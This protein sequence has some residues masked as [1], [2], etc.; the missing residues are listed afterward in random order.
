MSAINKSDLFAD[1]VSRIQQH[2]AQTRRDFQPLTAAQLAWSPQPKEWSILQCID[3]LNQTH[4]YYRARIAAATPIA[5]SPEADDYKPSF[6]ANIYMRFAFNPRFS[7]PAPP[8]TAPPAAPDAATLTTYLDKQRQ[9]LQLLEDA[10]S[11]DLRRTRIPVKRGLSFN[12]GD[13][14]KVLVYHDALHMGQ[15]E[16][17]R[18]A[19]LHDRMTG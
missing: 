19:L 3:H 9:L 5:A 8:Y 4:E 2:E 6:W 12:L 15:A 14:L 18:R 1:L 7:F 16:G 17:V 11:L 13:C 10:E